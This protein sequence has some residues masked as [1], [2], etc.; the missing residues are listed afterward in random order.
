LV[1]RKVAWGWLLFTFLVM[2]AATL[3]DWFTRDGKG[4][5]KTWKQRLA[6]PNW[7]A[8]VGMSA[9]FGLGAG[10]FVQQFIAPTEFDVLRGILNEIKAGQTETNT[11]LDEA[12]ETLRRVE[13][14][15]GPKPWRAFE[16][17][18]GYWGEER[19]N[20]QVVYLIQR[21]DHAL[22]VTLVRK[23]PDM[24]D[25]RMTAS[26]TRHGQG[27]VLNAVMRTSTE[28]DETDG[29]SLVFTYHS[30]GGQYQRLD[31]LNETRSNAGIVK[32]EPCGAPE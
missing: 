31:W 27:D 7:V 32:L 12:N 15:T 9:F 17:I 11:K 5:S 14:Q 18:D 8:R 28:P 1:E 16:N 19:H 6:N 21:R 10:L 30:D 25:Y 23:E 4:K 24:G 3:A 29:Q 26:I 13:D 20:C 22:T 2:V